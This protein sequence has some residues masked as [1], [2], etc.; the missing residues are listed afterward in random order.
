MKT[1]D[2]VPFDE[3]PRSIPFVAGIV[4]LGL[5]SLV[6]FTLAAIQILQFFSMPI[7]GADGGSFLRG[8]LLQIYYGT[9]AF[10]TLGFGILSM[11]I[12]SKLET[13]QAYHL[14][15][16][17]IGYVLAV[18]ITWEVAGG[19]F[20]DS[21]PLLVGI[22]GTIVFAVDVLY[23]DVLS[24]YDIVRVRVDRIFESSND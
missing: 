14:I 17:T 21:F 24:K 2:G 9:A 16:V 3:Y 23:I 7:V 11:A 1:I 5:I 15:T 19:P 20:R 8:G 6:Q 4:A 13:R 10:V 18:L 22:A 12:L